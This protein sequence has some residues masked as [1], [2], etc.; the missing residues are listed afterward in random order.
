MKVE[1]IGWFLCG[2]HC[3]NAITQAIYKLGK[4]REPTPIQI[5]IA[6][7]VAGMVV[8]I[9]SSLIF[10]RLVKWMTKREEAIFWA[11][12]L[13][14]LGSLF[15][16]GDPQNIRGYDAIGGVYV[17]CLFAYAAYI[18]P[19]IRYEEYKTEPRSLSVMKI[20]DQQWKEDKEGDGM[21]IFDGIAVAYGFKH[22]IKVTIKSRRPLNISKAISAIEHVKFRKM[23]NGEFES[24]F[25]VWHNTPLGDVLLIPQEK[26]ER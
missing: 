11:S 1:N 15:I 4:T 17:I 18:Y 2:A 24:T 12:A 26:P 22:D 10:V 14:L 9:N 23:E 20:R 16:Y 5:G 19:R 6:L 8:A 13:I 3:V 7:V 25:D 21:H